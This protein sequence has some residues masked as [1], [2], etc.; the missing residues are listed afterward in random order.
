MTSGPCGEEIDRAVSLAWRVPGQFRR[1]EARF[2]YRLARRKGHLVEIGCY[3][4]RTTAVLLQ[5]AR[6]WRATMTT[7]DPFVPLP[8]EVPRARPEIWR[9]NLRGVGLERPE[10]LDVTSDRAI[11]GWDRE[12]GFLFIDGDHG[13]EAVRRDLA[14][15]TPF[16]AIGGVVALHDMWFPSITGVAQAARGTTEGAGNT[17]VSADE[18]SRMATALQ[19]LMSQFKL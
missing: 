16:V 1:G 2:L 10:L 6:V 4:G 8:N 14:N 15:W 7:I 3:M 11:T 9:Q 19:Q 13:Y 18:L 12:I 5:A 17:K